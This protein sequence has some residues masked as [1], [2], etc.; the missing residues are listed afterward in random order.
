MENQPPALET[1]N[2]EQPALPAPSQPKQ[3]KQYFFEGLMIFLAVVLGFLAENIREYISDQERAK[4]FA[5]LLLKDLQ[6]DTTALV[7]YNNYY[8]NANNCADTLIKL[9]GENEPKNIPSGKLYWYGLFAAGSRYLVPNDATLKQLIS[10]GSIR[11]FKKNVAEEVAK[12][13]RCLRLIQ[14]KDEQFL[15]IYTETRKARAL[16]F[17]FK[18]LEQANNIFALLNK[19][20]PQKL[21]TESPQVDAFI[22]SNPPLLDNDV[23]KFNQFMEMIRS[24]FLKQY[25]IYST[26]ALK[27]A[28]VLMKIL[29]QEYHLKN[30][31]DADK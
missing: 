6:M 20:S 7:V 27:Q 1:L 17:N 19:D 13:E 2:V 23:V 28:K 16:L 29:Q 15:G 31:N 25:V 5:A 4:D 30:S 21:I 26:D 18:Y 10:S 3:F 9:L 22:K 12:Y 14:N 8:I 11:Y 24:R